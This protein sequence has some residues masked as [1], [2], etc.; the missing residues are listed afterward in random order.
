MIYVI[1]LLSLLMAFTFP[2]CVSLVIAS[3]FYHHKRKSLI[4][5]AIILGGLFLIT[6]SSWS[7]LLITRDTT[8]SV[9]CF[10]KEDKVEK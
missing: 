1:I 8:N 7:V 5:T 9:Q 4:V 6:A 2:A 10:P 3:Y